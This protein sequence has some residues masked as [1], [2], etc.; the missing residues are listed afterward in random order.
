MQG[1]IT[2]QAAGLGLM[3]ATSLAMAQ[4]PGTAESPGAIQQQQQ[5]EI[6]PEE[7]IKGVLEGLLR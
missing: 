3:M 1:K 5:Q 7:A 4:Q 2:R 6:T